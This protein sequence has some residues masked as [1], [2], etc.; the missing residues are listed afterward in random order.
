[1]TP[2]IRVAA[3]VIQRQDGKVLICQRGTGRR[4]AFLWEFP[5][6]KLEPGET[7]AACLERELMEELSLPVHGLKELCS[8][9]AQGIQFLFLKGHTQAE[10]V[11]SEHLDY[12]FVSPREMLQYD[13]CP[14]DVPVARALALNDP[15]VCNFFW[16]FDG[17]LMDTYPAMVMALCHV[18]HARDIPMM[19]EEALGLLK[20]SLSRGLEA[21]GEDTEQLLAE[22]RQQERRLLEELI[23]PVAGIPEALAALPGK[24]CLVTHR[25]QSAMDYLAAANLAHYFTDSVT[26]DDGFPRKPAPDGLL[27][28]MHKH[29]LDPNTCI[30]IGDRPLDIAAGRNA[31]MLT[32]LLDA[33]KFFPDTPCDIR[34][35]SGWELLSFRGS[36]KNK[37]LL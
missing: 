4:N 11:L 1:M 7:A 9:Q 16:D 29:G 15:P 17:T 32:C 26:G 8:G 34:V 19:P 6:G 13:F 24:H 18:A 20:F 10:P 35:A 21:I 37:S 12:A 2:T 28:L 30:M 3:G 31:G 36:Q 22:Y 25:D 27:H 5:G 33:E 14:A 23:R